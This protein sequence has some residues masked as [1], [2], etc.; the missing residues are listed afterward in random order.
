VGI[1]DNANDDRWM[2]LVFLV[3]AYEAKRV[4]YVS[5]SIR[6]VEKLSVVC[7]VTH[8]HISEWILNENYLVFCIGTFTRE[9]LDIP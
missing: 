6:P 7:K 5:L 1:K 3:K 2:S 4:L 9:H 8:Y